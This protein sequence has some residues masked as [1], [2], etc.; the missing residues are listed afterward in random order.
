MKKFCT[1]LIIF[2]FAAFLL[3]GCIGIL[4]SVEYLPY[5]IMGAFAFMVMDL[6]LAAVFLTTIDSVFE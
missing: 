1:G 2:L 4:L 5:A 3:V 6:C